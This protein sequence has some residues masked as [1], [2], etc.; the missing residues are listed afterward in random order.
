M[1]LF[2]CGCVALQDGNSGI[3]GSAN[4]M[5]TLVVTLNGS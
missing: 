1:K 5:W 2:Q 3:R 4:S